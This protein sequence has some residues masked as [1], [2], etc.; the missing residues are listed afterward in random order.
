MPIDP[1]N[2]TDVHLPH[3]DIKSTGHTDAVTAPHV[4]TP[5]IHTDASKIHT[6]APPHHFDV[7]TKPPTQP[8]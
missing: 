6:D 2:H 4:D 8:Q 5:P 1:I 3:T 7:V